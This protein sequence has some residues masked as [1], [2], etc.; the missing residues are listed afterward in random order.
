MGNQIGQ[1]SMGLGHKQELPG[2]PGPP[3]LPTSANN[4]VSVDPVSGKIVFG[5]AP[6]EAGNPGA[7][8][9][10][11]EMVLNPNT[12]VFWI[13]TLGEIFGIL[14]FTNGTVGWGVNLGSTQDA[15]FVANKLSGQARIT[16]A[17]EL[18]C[19]TG[20][21]TWSC[22][23]PPLPAG[24]SRPLA[25]DESDQQIKGVVGAS[26]T[27]TTADAKTVTVVDGIV[28]SIV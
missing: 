18:L 11:R 3:F 12:T 9:S 1:G 23:A 28:T 8:I 15:T 26:G 22:I 25:W 7:V 17:M 5:Q 19:V 6:G 2:P 14:D 20:I 27:F 10:N 24:T 13:D 16:A 21:I 4:G